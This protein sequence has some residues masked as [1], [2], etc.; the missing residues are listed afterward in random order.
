MSEVLTLV[1]VAATALL[2]AGAVWGA[3]RATELFT[4]RVEHGKANHVR[5]RIPAALF[6][7]IQEIVVRPPIVQATLRAVTQGGVPALQVSGRVHQDQV[8][9]LRNV[10]GRFPAARIRAGRRAVG[11]RRR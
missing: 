6:R 3:R 9:R 2:V 8:Q 4:V 11:S 10:L 5:G 7:E 1:G